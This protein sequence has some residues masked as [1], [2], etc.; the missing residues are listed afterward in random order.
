MRYE[1]IEFQ[2]RLRVFGKGTNSP[3]FLSFNARSENPADGD[4]GDKLFW[5]IEDH[6]LGVVIRP[7]PGTRGPQGENVKAVV[8][9]AGEIRKAI[10]ATEIQP[11]AEPAKA[12]QAQGPNQRR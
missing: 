7:M 1:H 11:K 12:P 8:V 5:S 2:R 3:Q 9:F 6:P 4:V 10:E